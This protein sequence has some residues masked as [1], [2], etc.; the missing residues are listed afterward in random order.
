MHNEEL[1]SFKMKSKQP[2]I[3]SLL[4]HLCLYLLVLVMPLESPSVREPQEV[5]IMYQNEKSRQ[6][7]MDPNEDE[8]DK[9]VK[10]L[11][12]RAERL[13]RLSRRFKK[14]TIA[15]NEGATQNLSPSN[16]QPPRENRLQKDALTK[17]LQKP[18]EDASAP[19]INRPPPDHVANRTQMGVSTLSE[20]IP[21]VKTGGFTALN[22][23]QFIHYTFYARANEQIR[24]R[25]VEN[26]R[27]FINSAPQT[28][29]NRL[30]RSTQISE[31][32]IILS[33]TGQFVK[34]I[35]HQKAESQDLDQSAIAAFRLA[36]PFNNPPSEMIENDGYIHLHYGFHVQF[37]PRYMAG[38]SK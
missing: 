3:I 8:L 12:D 5:E 1:N 38:G 11:K 6:F 9:S 33:P 2:L 23:D 37:K 14:E 18:L 32:E 20:Y 4:I 17:E 31:I 29:I 24:N 28:E 27:V 21:E 35:I 13:S 26:I 15:P 7:V 36:A 19:S 10:D 16:R 30:A 22:T 25:W 34:A